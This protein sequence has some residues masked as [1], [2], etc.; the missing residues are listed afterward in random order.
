MRS[1]RGSVSAAECS[2]SVGLAAQGLPEL[3]V[4]GVRSD[5]ARQLVEPWG[6][7][8]LDESIVLPG[9]ALVSGPFVM[10]AVEV[11]RPE[12]HLG[13][14]VAVYGCGVRVFSWPG[15]TTGAGGRGKPGTGPGAPGSRCWK[16][17]GPGPTSHRT[18]GPHGG[19][20]GS[21]S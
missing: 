6:T 3:V 8:L 7:Y 12:D 13:L 11:E 16:S 10:E 17:V 15:P 4:V 2:C 20:R 1:V 19:G 21:A 5:D 14:A 18:W 9:E